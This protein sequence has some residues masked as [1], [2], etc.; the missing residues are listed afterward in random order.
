MVCSSSALAQRQPSRVVEDAR[1]Q[2]A[3]TIVQAIERAQQRAVGARTQAVTPNI[4]PRTGTFDLRRQVLVRPPQLPTRR[5]I[6]EWRLGVNTERAPKGL[7]ISE[8]SRYS[9]AWKY[10]IEEGDYLLDVMGYAVGYD[11]GAYY[12]LA[13]TLNQVVPADGWVSILIWNKRTGQEEATW[14]QLEGR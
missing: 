11:N 1:Q 5:V 4:D 9:P 7:R 13:E 10:G 8:V 12:S 14:L 2:G 3:R 6:Q